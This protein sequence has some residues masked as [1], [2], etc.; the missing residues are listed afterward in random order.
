MHQNYEFKINQIND[1]KLITNVEHESEFEGNEGRYLEGSAFQVGY[2]RT[3]NL[4][5]GLNRSNPV[6]FDDLL[7]RALDQVDPLRRLYVP[8]RQRRLG[9]HELDFLHRGQVLHVCCT[10]QQGRDLGN[11]ILQTK[12]KT[13]KI[14]NEVTN[15]HHFEHN[16]I[17]ASFL[18]MITRFEA[19][20]SNLI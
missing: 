8:D 20:I 7:P 13:K 12:K 2:I 14:Q 3:K 5:L 6:F 11:V 4:G 9:Q 1:F 18:R 15:A 16:S 19:S 10:V 17:K